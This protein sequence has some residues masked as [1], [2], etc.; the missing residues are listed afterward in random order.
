MVRL[1]DW[2]RVMMRMMMREREEDVDDGF[3]GWST[4][5]PEG[6]G[7]RAALSVCVYVW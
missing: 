2:K 3:L 5:H 6:E 7:N 1:R 4:I